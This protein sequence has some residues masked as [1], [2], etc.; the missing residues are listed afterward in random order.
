MFTEA[1]PHMIKMLKDRDYIAALNEITDDIIAVFYTQLFPGYYTTPSRDHPVLRREPRQMFYPLWEEPKENKK[2]LTLFNISLEWSSRGSPCIVP[3]LFHE[4][5][6]YRAIANL[7]D[8]SVQVAFTSLRDVL[9]LLKTACKQSTSQYDALR[10]AQLKCMKLRFGKGLSEFL[11]KLGK[12]R[13][14]TGI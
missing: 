9:V 11:T 6:L 10:S 3:F 2:L 5:D 8:E 13:G 4:G 12:F 7:Q 14:A 1:H